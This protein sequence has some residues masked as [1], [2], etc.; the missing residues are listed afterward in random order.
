[1][2]ELTYSYSKFG[3]WTFTGMLMG[4]TNIFGSFFPPPT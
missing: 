4:E 1:M 2:L 3:L